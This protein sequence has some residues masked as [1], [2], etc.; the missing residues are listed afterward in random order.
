MNDYKKSVL[1]YA[2]VIYASFIFALLFSGRA[3]TRYR[4]ITPASLERI[5]LIDVIV[6]VL[7]TGG[8]VLMAAY[9]Q[10]CDR[11]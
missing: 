9:A 11:I 4:C 3:F 1:D 7:G 8:I 5:G 10:L 2:G 6:L